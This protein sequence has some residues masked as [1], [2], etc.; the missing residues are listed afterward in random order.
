MTSCQSLCYPE[1]AV[2]DVD[3]KYSQF[4]QLPVGDGKVSQTKKRFLAIISTLLEKL[5]QTATA[6]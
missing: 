4:P 5:H 3:L 1:E 2:K 6:V